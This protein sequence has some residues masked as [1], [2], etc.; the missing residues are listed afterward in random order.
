MILC[1]SDL[2]V[3]EGVMDRKQT[4]VRPWIPNWYGQETFYSLCCRFHRL[5]GHPLAAHTSVQLFGDRFGALRHDVSGHVQAFVDRTWTDRGDAAA[6]LLGRTVLRYYLRFRDAETRRAVIDRLLNC[7]PQALKQELGLLASGFGASHPLRACEACVEDDVRSLGMPTWHLHHQLPGVLCCPVHRRTLWETKLKV[8]GR[9]RL[10]WL[11]PDD[12]QVNDRQLCLSGDP[13]SMAWRVAQELADDITELQAM[14]IDFSVDRAREASLFRDRLRQLDLC[15]AGD[16]LRIQ[17]IR[18]VLFES[19]QQYRAIPPLSA[20]AQTYKAAE[21]TLRRLLNPIGP[22]MHPLR[23]M[24]VIRWLFGSWASFREIYESPPRTTEARTPTFPTAPKKRP[25]SVGATVRDQVVRLI[26]EGRSVASAARACGVSTNSALLWAEHDGVAVHR[27]PKSIDDRTRRHIQSSLRKGMAKID[28]ARR[29]T[30]S[31]VTITR[32]LLAT[33][34]LR[35]ERER[36]L[37]AQRQQNARRALTRYSR[38]HPDFSPTDIKRAI[39]AD[40]VWALRHDKEWFQQWCASL[41][42][43]RSHA[44]SGRTNWE[45][46]DLSF[47]RSIEKLISASGTAAPTFKSVSE[48]VRQVP[49]LRNH[50]R[51]LAKLPRTAAALA[52][53][54]M[55]LI[56]S[57]RTKQNR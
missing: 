28:I 27:R 5:V 32:I 56:A 25:L 55:I 16:R 45:E 12:I 43:G 47:V 42:A 21:A 36:R 14:P 49:G 35:E 31:V 23:H 29:W 48:L 30:V 52:A 34:G 38:G 39:T 17:S 1:K 6:I 7:G 46:R 24:V 54:T 3:M 50:V 26:R 2:L 13:Q 44:A 40:F 37:T 11:L 4:P 8:D 9:K 33:P 18:P 10:L 57:K 15:G 20:L 51:H 41:P 53:A 22:P 19:L